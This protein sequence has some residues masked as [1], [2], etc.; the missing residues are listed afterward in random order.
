MPSYE[1][2][3]STA[4]ITL[5]KSDMLLADMTPVGGSDGRGELRSNLAPQPNVLERV[6]AAHEAMTSALGRDQE[7]SGL[8][9]LRQH[10]CRSGAVAAV[11]SR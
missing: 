10:W 11:T 9:S 6:A 1:K 4:V 8:R 5:S 3:T 2:P 7:A